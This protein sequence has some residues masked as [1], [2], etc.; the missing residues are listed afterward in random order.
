MVSSEISLEWSLDDVFPS[1]DGGEQF[2][3]FVDGIRSHVVRLKAALTRQDQDEVLAQWQMIAA[4]LRHAFGYIACLGVQDQFHP[5]LQDFQME[6]MELEKEHAALTVE[7][8]SFLASISQAD[9]E[10]WMAKKENV[11]VAPLLSVRKKQLAHRMKP[12]Q[13]LLALALSRESFVPVADIY[14]AVAS[15]L[16]VQV[17]DMGA[18]D[19]YSAQTLMRTGPSLEREKVFSAYENCWKKQGNIFRTLINQV[20]GYRVE[21]MHQRKVTDPLEESLSI[22]R[23]NRSSV[24]MMWR[25]VNDRKASLILFLSKKALFYKTKKANWT[26]IWADLEQENKTPL[27]LYDA[28]QWVQAAMS[29]MGQEVGDFCR[30]LVSSHAITNRGMKKMGI[31][32]FTLPLP[33]KRQVRIFL[34]YHDGIEHLVDYGRQL[35]NAWRYHVLFD[36][37]EILQHC[38]VIVCEAFQ[39]F[40]ERLV[41]E[42]VKERAFSRQQHFDALF[43]HVQRAA[44]NIMD[45][46]VRY[47]FESRLFAERSRGPLSEERLCDLML[48]AQRIT[49]ANQLGSYFPY[50][51]ASKDHFYHTTAAPFQNYP[52]TMGYLL[53]MSLYKIYQDKP[54]GF[55]EKVKRWIQ[56]STLQPSIENSLLEQF[57]LRLD[58]ENIWN[59]AIDLLEADVRAL[60]DLM[61]IKDKTFSLE[62]KGY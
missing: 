28:T 51:W 49:Y 25:V 48:E 27:R 12:E 45:M 44:I 54:Q 60:A 1:N 13:E 59:K 18:M 26:D 42:V 7:F 21:L 16:A 3:I 52:Q 33:L 22:H 30:S 29:R 8:E 15:R 40:A 36:F 2:L 53:G 6:L 35:A 41:L 24:D 20:Y 46:Q 14:R 58:N 62:M 19:I 56:Q 23:V 32:S 61:E 37:P 43:S 10:K 55:M 11:R 31:N 5:R 9:F 38:P 17:P 34:G 50:Y 57:N 47:V 4:S 39:V